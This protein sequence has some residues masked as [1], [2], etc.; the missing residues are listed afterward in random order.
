MTDAL[1]LNEDFRDLLLAL[2]E[3]GV[4]F[5]VVG[6]HALAAYGV[7]RAT[8]D[9]D[10]LVR[11]AADNAER[12]LTGLRAFGAP[13][14]A[15]GVTRDDLTPPSAATASSTRASRSANQGTGIQEA[16]E[17]S[18]S[19]RGLGPAARLCGKVPP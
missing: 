11:P 2:T 12:V 13:V 17:I 5:L 15:H 16:C 7:V 9:L 18:S 10:V 3:A 1:D 8:G 19:G 14:G 4:D 6:A